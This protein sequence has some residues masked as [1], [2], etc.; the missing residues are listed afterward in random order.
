MIFDVSGY[1]V[2][3]GYVEL[4]LN[5]GFGVDF[6]TLPLEKEGESQTNG[7]TNS[8][9][10]DGRAST[11]ESVGKTWSTD[12]NS[13]TCRGYVSS[14][15]V[16]DLSMRKPMTQSLTLHPFQGF[17]YNGTNSSVVNSSP[18]SITYPSSLASSHTTPITPTS[19]MISPIPFQLRHP[20]F[21]CALD[22]D[23]LKILESFATKVKTDIIDIANN[24]LT[25][26]L[27]TSHPQPGNTET[28]QHICREALESLDYIT[29][30]DADLTLVATHVLKYGVTTFTPTIISSYPAVYKQVRRRFRVYRSHLHRLLSFKTAIQNAFMHSSSTSPTPSSASTSS[31]PTSTGATPLDTLTIIPLLAEMTGLHLE[32]PFISVK[33]AHDET[34]MAHPAKGLQ[35]VAERYGWVPIN[36]AL[37]TQKGEVSSQESSTETR[38]ECNTEPVRSGKVGGEVDVEYDMSDTSIITIAPELDNALE[39]ISAITK[40]TSSARYR[41]WFGLNKYDNNEFFEAKQ[42][43]EFA[44][45]MDIEA[46]GHR[47]RMQSP[48]LETKC[49]V[50]IGHTR[51]TLAQSEAA[52]TQGA[53]L[54]THLFNAM[55]G[56]HHRDPGIIGLLGSDNKVTVIVFVFICYYC[57]LDKAFNTIHPPPVSPQHSPI[58]SSYSFTD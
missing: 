22:S 43:P 47:H 42:R 31:C 1:Y 33:G 50:S 14:V 46:Q 17:G 25:T 28:L 48:L 2:V 36:R 52:V 13:D 19:P 53:T 35:T 18:E 49:I 41:S 40:Q 10:S 57:S 38:I 11:V 20:A 3:P 44:R 30:G 26:S 5:G 29:T 9:A 45:D 24:H 32:G 16:N 55:R 8:E 58:T 23:D 37:P 6:T 54:I 56:F 34:A 21:P 51:A 39:T 4:Q 12:S 27:P 7:R 15:N